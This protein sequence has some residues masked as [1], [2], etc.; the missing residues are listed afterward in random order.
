MRRQWQTALS[1]F[2]L[3]SMAGA[4]MVLVSGE[5][6][7]SDAQGMT[8]VVH[9][10]FEFSALQKL[11]ELHE[12]MVAQGLPLI[13][14]ELAIVP[15]SENLPG[16]TLRLTAPE[17]VWAPEGASL[18]VSSLGDVAL[19]DPTEAD[20]VALAELG[21]ASGVMVI[22]ESGRVLALA[23]LI[24]SG[25]L[26]TSLEAP[27]GPLFLAAAAEELFNL[28]YD[29][30]P[31]VSSC[32]ADLDAATHLYSDPVDALTGYFERLGSI[33]VTQRLAIE[34]SIE[35]T[36]EEVVQQNG[37]LVD[38]VTGRVMAPARNDLIRQL[39]DGVNPESLTIRPAIPLGVK[40]PE[41]T[42]GDSSDDLVAVFVSSPSG[43]VLG[44][45]PMAPM[46]AM[47]EDGQLS[48]ITERVIEL[49]PPPPEEDL[50]VF[51]RSFD[52][53]DFACSPS[54]D[55]KPILMVGFDDFAGGSRSRIDLETHTVEPA[56]DL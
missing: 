6:S 22:D 51:I 29:P 41:A 27:T 47:S 45:T 33:P 35:S 17:I 21:S 9:Q 18:E 19:A 43:N 2:V 30:V 37:E 10:G 5:P 3:G 4:A 28:Q 49:A 34:A 48:P 13:R 8:P 32:A 50:M 39:R 24:D 38:A 26:V 16:P 11:A 54:Q 14:A 40:V 44:W 46:F 20:L 53:E 1:L 7:T 52:Q 15:D 36:V 31:R 42:Q 55:E 12:T 56:T 25:S 23:G